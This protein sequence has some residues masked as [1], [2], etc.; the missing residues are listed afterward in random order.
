MSGSGRGTDNRGNRRKHYNKR[1][2]WDV[3]QSKP[4]DTP[5][6]G[7]KKPLDLSIIGEGR[8]EKTRGG[9]V[10]RPKWT[11]PRPSVFS[12]PQV[13][14]SW[15]EK[16]GKGIMTA[17][18]EPDTGKAVHFEC[19]INRISEREFLDTGDAVGYIGGGRFGI[20]HYNNPPDTKDFKIKKVFEWENK[21][22]RGEWR[23]V[24]S[25][26]FSVT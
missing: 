5:K 24:I 9:L 26:Y 12:M 16:P 14:C 3:S 4:R 17:I 21:E 6:N 2:D 20:I 25:D 8:F 7:A 10:E 13:T 11:S 18:C 19:V 15:C 22:H 1:R 23:D